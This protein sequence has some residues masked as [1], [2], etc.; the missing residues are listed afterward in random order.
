MLRSFSLPAIAL[1]SL[2]SAYSQAT[3]H[4]T[5]TATHHPVA[6][7]VARTECV[8]LPEISPKVPA[9]PAGTP[10]PKALIT[11]AENITFAPV[12]SPELRAMFP[13][14]PMDFSLD[15]QDI[16]VGTGEPA[17]P[18][19]FYTVKYTGYL[20]D[21]TKFDSSEDHP[22][23]KNGYTFPYGGRGV[24]AGWN[25]GFEGMRI[26]GKRRLFVPYQLAYGERGNP[27]IPPKSELIFDLELVS[28][29]TTPP[30]PPAPP[31]G[32][33]GSPSNP[34][35][36]GAP[37]TPGTPG[38]PGNPGAPTPPQPGAPGSTTPQP[39]NP[40][41]GPDVKPAPAPTTA[42]VG[43]QSPPPAPKQ[44]PQGL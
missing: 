21:G 24:I 38:A 1:L 43:P 22:E 27:H 14:L 7:P 25:M 34:A 8:K 13:N 26:G 12:V 35:T 11:I 29:S 40:Q 2:P 28:Q 30:T 3:A 32:A 4:H 18:H 23:V 16:H 31:A 9:V 39:A 36:P 17:K 20:T 19:M 6:H 33:P 37:A 15:Y 42:P 10:C 41:T 44:P 5:T